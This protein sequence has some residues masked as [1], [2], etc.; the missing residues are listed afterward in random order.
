MERVSTLVRDFSKNQAN[1]ESQNVDEI[2]D[3]DHPAYAWI[4]RASHYWPG[5]IDLIP[6]MKA[7][8][9]SMK[10]RSTTQKSLANK[11]PDQ[12][13]LDTLQE[14]AAKFGTKFKELFC[15][16]ASE[17]ADSIQQ[18]LEDV[19]VLF[20]SIMLTS[21]VD[22]PRKLKMFS[23]YVPSDSLSSLEQGQVNPSFGRGQV[24]FL[25]RQAS[26]RDALR[27]QAA[28]FNFAT[29]TYIMPSLAQSM[30]VT[31]GELS[32]Q[33]HQIQRS[34]SS[35]S[36]LEP[37]VHIACFALRP[38]YHPR[39]W[40][41]LVNKDKK[42][43]LPSVRLTTNSLPPWKMEILRELD[44][45]TP[46]E[47]SLYLQNRSID[48]QAEEVDFLALVEEAIGSLAAQIDHPLFEG[49]RF[50][51]RPYTVPCRT[52][53]SSP[54]RG[55]ALVMMFRVIA[56]AHYNRSLNGM[57]EFGSARL[58]RAQQHV[59]PR[60]PDH[61]AFARQVHL[62]FAG[63]AEARA[64]TKATSPA[65]SGHSTPRRPSASSQTSSPIGS[66]VKKG[67]HSLRPS[68]SG[69]ITG[70]FGFGNRKPEQA[71]KARTFF[72]GIHVQRDISVEVSEM[73]QHDGTETGIES[74]NLGVHNE[75]TVAPTEIDTFADEL[76]LLLIEERRQQSLRGRDR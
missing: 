73:G 18:P 22:K 64:G 44:N 9:G 61:G 43:L 70:K 12:I 69:T 28:G 56:D 29:L 35:P 32:M 13:T 67:E 2:F 4:Y 60:S 19:G 66:V 8:L 38:K 33:L 68:S 23:R 36:M 49:A 75:V 21:T 34:L 14:E 51:A 45:L 46:P 40:T 59:Y 10:Y 65:T 20:E 6:G 3:T 27:L 31:M 52:S 71:S 50:V 55:R 72:G 26:K 30:E 47:C 24:L 15:V 5:V 17:L 42:N 25:V 16:A 53:Q 48:G 11:L 74:S 63:L 37:G 58:F 1:G 57:F 39:G 7:H 76:M 62:E 41:V 54:T